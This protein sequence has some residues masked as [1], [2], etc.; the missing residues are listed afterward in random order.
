[1][2]KWQR[3]EILNFKHQIPNNIKITVQNT[4]AQNSL[5]FR[6][7]IFGFVWSL[8]FGIWSLANGIALPLQANKIVGNSGKMKKTLTRRG[9]MIYIIR[10]LKIR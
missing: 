7:L 3:Y 9:N 6:I 5:A 2:V 8:D 4:N 10:Q 1:M